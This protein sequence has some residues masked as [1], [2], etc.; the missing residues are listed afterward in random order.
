MT[1]LTTKR[2][3][4]F[5]NFGGL[6]LTD[7]VL[8]ICS[9]VIVQWFVSNIMKNIDAPDLDAEELNQRLLSN[10]ANNL[11]FKFQYLFS[12]MIGCLIYRIMTMLQ[13][14]ES[15]G[16]LFKI[17]GKMLTDFG[18]FFAIYLILLIMFAIVG[19]M[20][21]IQYLDQ[22]RGSFQSILTIVDASLGNYDLNVY[23]NIRDPT[24]RLFGELLIMIVVVC[25]NILLMNFIIA[26]LANTYSIFDARS[27][28]LYLAKI[29]SSRAELNY[30]QSLGAFLLSMPIINLIQVPVLPISMTMRYGSPAIMALNN[31]LMMAQYSLF[32][33]I[34][35][36][37]FIVVTL[38]LIPI[39]WIVGIIDKIG[40]LS[41]LKTTNE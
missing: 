25:F 37:A 40:T 34:M 14:S 36:L 4:R 3:G 12:V 32:M 5:Y 30:D 15:I 24:T 6:H 16:P 23:G 9:M 11:D 26:I 27:N 29:L 38:M 1:F 7:S 28:G 33:I 10:F 17:L 35:F 19:N 21:F 31:T 18:S 22:Y 8:A 2:L 20:C 39:A 13:F 41:S